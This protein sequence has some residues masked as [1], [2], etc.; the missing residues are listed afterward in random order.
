M[1]NFLARGWAAVLN[2][3]L[4]SLAPSP[5]EAWRTQVLDLK[6]LAGF[7][8]QVE[9]QLDRARIDC[10][11]NDMT[12]DQLRLL[13]HYKARKVQER[14]HEAALHTCLPDSWLAQRVLDAIDAW[15]LDFRAM[16]RCP[17]QCADLINFQHRLHAMADSLY[18]YALARQDHWEEISP[19]R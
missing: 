16:S 12:M 6:A 1:G 5:H 9:A 19:P 3:G 14:L 2:K 13:W 4:R 15:S 18:L 11:H 7:L 8:L 17:L 10:L